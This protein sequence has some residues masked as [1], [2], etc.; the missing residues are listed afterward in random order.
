[1]TN[2]SSSVKTLIIALASALV[3]VGL[4]L[5]AFFILTRSDDGRGITLPTQTQTE[6][7]PDPSDADERL[8][9]QVSTQNVSDVVATLSRPSSYHQTLMLTTVW[10]D[11]SH[12]RM[13]EIWVS[14]GICR[15]DLEEGDTVRSCL[16]DGQTVYLW[17]QDDMVVTTFTIDKTVTLDDLMGIPTYESLLSVDAESITDA[18][19]LTLDDMGGRSCVYAQL[20][21]RNG[22]TDSFWVD[23]STG[24]LCRADS[25]NGQELI[26][27]LRETEVEVLLASDEVFST[28]FTLPNGSMPFA[29]EQ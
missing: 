29:S 27:K 24:L 3:L 26:Y 13:V 28:A 16:S 17:Y 15:V 4:I 23:V 1:M 22:F 7:E 21:D 9:L 8:F 20:T 6:I 18:G 2:R 10:A 12:D 11:G 19:Y 25:L 5:A 14:D